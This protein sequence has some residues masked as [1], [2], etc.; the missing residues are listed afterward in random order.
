MGMRVL[1][2]CVSMHLKHAVSVESRRGQGT[3]LPWNWSKLLCE[4]W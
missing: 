1:P 3:R 2:A 4:H